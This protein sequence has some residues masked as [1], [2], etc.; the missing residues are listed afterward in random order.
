VQSQYLAALKMLNEAVRKCPPALW[1]ASRDK[2]R[3]WFRAQHALYWSHRYLRWADRNFAGWK[4]HRTP[5]AS[6]PMSKSALLDYLAFIE[7]YV[8]SHGLRT[9][10]LEPALASMRHI[11]QHTGEL[12]ERL[13]SRAGI[14]LHWTEQ[15]RARSGS[16]RGPGG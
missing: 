16:G 3:F 2:D 9:D 5:H 13:G 7:Q 11:Q 6:R 1:D 4:G 8:A 14:Q 12:Y 15:V 10:K